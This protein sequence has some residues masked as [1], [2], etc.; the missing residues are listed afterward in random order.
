MA[1][2]GAYTRREG[3]EEGGAF[4]ARPQGLHEQLDLR[5][6][7]RCACKLPVAADALPRSTEASVFM[8]LA[9]LVALQ[10]VVDRPY[11]LVMPNNVNIAKQ[12]LQPTWTCPA[13]TTP[14]TGCPPADA[15]LSHKRLQQQAPSIPPSN[16]RG[17]LCRHM[18]PPQQV[19]TVMW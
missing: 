4:V 16:T 12:E 2:Q 11:R 15:P 5:L 8:A 10:S 9:T 7:L 14:T 17:S 1:S 18:Q 3:R 13:P 6:G 19:P